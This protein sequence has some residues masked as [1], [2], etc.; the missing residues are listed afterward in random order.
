VTFKVTADSQDP[1]ASQRICGD[2][3]PIMLSFTSPKVVIPARIAAASEPNNYHE[4]AWRLFVVADKQQTLVGESQTLYKYLRYSGALTDG[5]VAS[6]AAIGKL[7]QTTPPVAVVGDR[8]TEMDVMFHPGQLTSDLEFDAEPNQ[9][10]YRRVEYDITYVDCPD[11]GTQAPPEE[12]G[13]GGGCATGHSAAH[14]G[15]IGLLLTLGAL[16]ARKRRNR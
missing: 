3:G 4:Y 5:D 8:L 10:D 9:Q 12:A 13:G 2:L 15:G 14:G 6:H 11:G 1:P 7:T 16:F